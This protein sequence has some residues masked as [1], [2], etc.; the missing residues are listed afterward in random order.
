MEYAINSDSLSTTI[1][2]YTD[3]V[4]YNM[5]VTMR[6]ILNALIFLFNPTDS[7]RVNSMYKVPDTTYTG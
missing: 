5:M 7:Y 3:Y 1:H 6:K 2:T 4:P